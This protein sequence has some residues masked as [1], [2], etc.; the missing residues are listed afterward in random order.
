M[1]YFEEKYSLKY[2]RDLKNSLDTVEEEG[3]DRGI[4]EGIHKEIHKV[5]KNLLNNNVSIEI[6]MKATGLTKTQIEHLNN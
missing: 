6:I 5:A 3:Y 2:Y 1:E 4:E